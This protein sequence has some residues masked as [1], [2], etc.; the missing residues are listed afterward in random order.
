MSSDYLRT[1]LS[2]IKNKQVEDLEIEAA[3]ANGDIEAQNRLAVR[4]VTR[5]GRPFNAMFK[6]AFELLSNSLPAVT[7][8]LSFQSRKEL[9]FYSHLLS[10]EFKRVS[11]AGWSAEQDKKLNQISAMLRNIE[12]ILNGA[13]ELVE[14]QIAQLDSVNCKVDSKTEVVKDEANSQAKKPDYHRDKIPA[15]IFGEGFDEE[16]RKITRL[17]PYLEL[18]TWTPIEAAL[19]VCGIEP[20][21]DCY[22]IPKGAMSLGGVFMMGT[23]DPFHYA[24]RVLQ[25]WNSQINPPVKVRPADFVEWCRAKGINTD[26]LRDIKRSSQP[27][28]ITLPNTNPQPSIEPPILQPKLA[29]IESIGKKLSKHLTHVEIISFWIDTKEIRDVTNHYRETIKQKHSDE[30]S[31]QYDEKLT[32]A[33]HDNHELKDRYFKAINQAVADGDLK[34]ETSVSDSGVRNWKTILYSPTMLRTVQGDTGI[35]EGREVYV[36]H[37]INRDDF[38][39]WLEKTHQWPIPNDCSLAQWFETEQ[40]KEEK[41][42]YQEWHK[43]RLDDYLSRM[44][45]GNAEIA[46]I[47]F[48]QG[49]TEALIRNELGGEVF[50]V[51]W[52]F[53]LKRTE[54]TPEQAVRLFYGIDPKKYGNHCLP[55]SL[56]YLEDDAKLKGNM[57]PHQ[58][59]QFGLEQGI[60]LPRRILEIQ[61]PVARLQI[62]RTT[63]VKNENND[64]ESADLQ[65]EPNIE[66]EDLDGA[67]GELA[68]TTWFRK[69]WKLE[70]KPKGNDFFKV[71]KKYVNAEKSP[72][73]DW[74]NTSAKGPGIKLKTTTTIFE[75]YDKNLIQKLATRFK[76]E[77]DSQKS[78]SSKK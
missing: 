8:P 65:P 40:I 26:W 28:I 7:Q 25:L 71:L 23:D 20:P 9:C 63:D 50:R 68:Y 45:E 58:W 47:G 12:L 16:A 35:H 4:V 48:E 27:S 34:A 5:D 74:Y 73:L 60:P 2:S 29:S 46:K 41:E 13:P 61:E 49:V 38:R 59:K 36:Q 42:P 75:H 52:Q 51:N 21:Q 30:D 6:S 44:G 62:D 22:E 32:Q 33:I 53:W 18:E 19:L 17:T 66:T 10:G 14:K 69:I 77:E 39:A 1:A 3:I 15:P 56:A 55:V 37:M 43:Q 67:K 70:G 31:V 64:I 72:I 24:R 54:W 76:R 78:M 57:T 11:L